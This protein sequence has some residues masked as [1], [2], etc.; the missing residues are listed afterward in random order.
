EDFYEDAAAGALPNFSIVEPLYGLADDHPPAHPMA[1][2]VFVQ[3]VAKALAQGPQWNRSLLL[4]Y[5][6]EHGG[7]YDHVPPPT[8][9]DDRAADGFDRLGF[10]V[11]ALVV[12]PWAQRGAV[13]PNL[14]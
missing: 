10:R 3:S 14:Y 13:S 12:S 2:Q 9:P 11:P 4:V 5:Y 7:F 8:V 6:D 1:G